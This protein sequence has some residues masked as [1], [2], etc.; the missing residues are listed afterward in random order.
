MEQ[1]LGEQKNS[2]VFEI[3]K[4]TISEK[5][6]EIRQLEKIQLFFELSLDLVCIIGMD[7]YFKKISHSFTALMGYSNEE[8]LAI[9]YICFVYEEDREST[10]SKMND[11][12]NGVSLVNFE[13]RYVC[14]NGDL[15]WISWRSAPV[16]ESGLIYSTARDVTDQKFTSK[17]LNEY[18]RKLQKYKDDTEKSMGYALQLQNSLFPDQERFKNI[19]PSS[20]IMHSAKHIV[21]GDFFWFHETEAKVFLI[22]ADCTGH[23]MPG[24]L[25]SIIG[26]QTL[27]NAVKHKNIESTS[28]LVKELDKSFNT[29]LHN[30]D[31]PDK[32]TDGMD[33]A[34][35]II[36]KKT[37]M[38]E[39]S[40]V[41][42]PVYIVR[43]KNLEILSPSKYSIGS[44]LENVTI[45][46]STFQLEK[47]DMLYLFSD[48]YCDQFGGP[49]DKKFGQ[50]RFRNL[51]S[52]ISTFSTGGQNNALEKSLLEW[53]KNS[54]QTDD[55][56]VVGIKI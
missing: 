49:N 2:R 22:A 1:K 38:L 24:A 35:C 23:G 6:S 32:T 18:G 41:Q 40:G 45:E 16:V 37:L 26:L 54:D 28:A 11:L 27:K 21:S 15:I 50:N 7:G 13:N 20:F 9:P 42:N 56:M 39:Y 17:I 12:Q 25:L 3:F 44:N 8:I 53:Q 47:D 48:G 43:K 55:I 29:L 46:T 5:I 36:H 52:S 51:L 31:D 34:V 10:K 4:E 30:A 19:F 33:V 14:K